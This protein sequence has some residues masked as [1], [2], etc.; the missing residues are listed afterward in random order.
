MTPLK[1]GHRALST[2]IKEKGCE[3]LADVRWTKHRQICVALGYHNCFT[4]F[5]VK[6]LECLRSGPKTIGEIAAMR[7]T[8]YNATRVM[9]ARLRKRGLLVASTKVKGIGR[10]LLIYSL[11]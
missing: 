9:L 7:G 10:P 3:C 5:E 6:W 11:P 2:R 8:E 1:L 4:T